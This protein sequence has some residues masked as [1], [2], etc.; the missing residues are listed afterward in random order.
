LDY[1]FRTVGTPTEE[2]WPGISLLPNFEKMGKIQF[3]GNTLRSTKI[4]EQAMGLLERILVVDPS[5]RA[6]ARNALTHAYFLSKP[7]PPSDPSELG[8][9]FSGGQSFHE[10][11]TKSFKRKEEETK[12]LLGSGSN[13]EQPQPPGS[14]TTTNDNSQ[15]PRKRTINETR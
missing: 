14:A 10:Y 12:K 1:I 4:S 15:N 2:S 5:R 13:S 11:Q 8:V 3:F 9:L 6:S 7:I